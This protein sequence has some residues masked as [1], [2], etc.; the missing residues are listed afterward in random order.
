MFT[1]LGVI[2]KDCQRSDGRYSLQFDGGRLDIF[3][4]P[5][6]RAILESEISELPAEAQPRSAM[7]ERALKFSTTQMKSRRETLALNTVL[8]SLILQR[9]MAPTLSPMETEAAVEQFMDAVHLWCRF[10]KSV[11]VGTS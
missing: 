2:P 4:M 8:N 11:N 7:L 5:G 3:P 9:I 10:I 1:R 6:D